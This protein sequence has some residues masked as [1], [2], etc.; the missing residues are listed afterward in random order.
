MRREKILAALRA[1]VPAV[2][3]GIRACLQWRG[4]PGPTTRDRLEHALGFVVRYPDVVLATGLF[5]GVV[6]MVLH[7]S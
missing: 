7:W 5:V 2:E 6:V 1:L 3:R 4:L